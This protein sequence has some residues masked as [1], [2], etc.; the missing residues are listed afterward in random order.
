MTQLCRRDLLQQAH[1]RLRGL[2]IPF[3]DQLLQE[4]DENLKATDA[5]EHDS[6]GDYTLTPDNSCWI[7]VDGF[8]VY[9]HRTDEGV[10]VDITAKGHE[11]ETP[12]GSTYAFTAELDE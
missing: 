11:D 7:T 2:G 3:D 8:S 10:V 9:I 6:G 1:D 5:L 12:L 4:L